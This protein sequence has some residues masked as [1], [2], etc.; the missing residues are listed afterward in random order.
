MGL[1]L[2]VGAMGY[3]LMQPAINV[4]RIV[5]TDSRLRACYQHIPSAHH[6]ACSKV[7]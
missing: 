1:A 3:F 4:R 2:W 6:G 5:T 7:R